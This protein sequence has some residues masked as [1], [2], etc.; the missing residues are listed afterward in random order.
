MTEPLAYTLNIK[1]YGAFGAMWSLEAPDGRM[2]GSWRT[3]MSGYGVWLE[4]ADGEYR[5]T[6]GTDTFD[7]RG[8]TKQILRRW[9]VEH[10]KTDARFLVAGRG[11][12]ATASDDVMY[13]DHAVRVTVV[14]ESA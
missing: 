11:N 2:V 7:V 3:A 10:A 9:A 14:Q 4:G 1:T 6:Q 12:H 8:N 13:G 5:Q